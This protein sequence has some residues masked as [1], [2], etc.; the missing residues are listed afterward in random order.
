[1]I[2]FI[3]NERTKSIKIGV[4]NNPEKRIKGLQTSNE[5]KLNILCI[6][7][8]GYLEEKR[9]HKRFSE[10]RVSGEWFSYNNEIL[11]YLDKSE[12]IFDGFVYHDEWYGKLDVFISFTFNDFGELFRTTSFIK[13]SLPD[14]KILEYDDQYVLLKHIPKSV[15]KPFHIEKLR[16]YI[17]NP[18]RNHNYKLVGVYNSEISAVNKMIS[19]MECNK[20]K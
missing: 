14:V 1:M 6:M 13:P 3:Q 16:R 20:K 11:E 19:F 9:L 12:N 10:Y 8:G 15:I 7:N 4:S 17:D 2:Y 18:P 5:D